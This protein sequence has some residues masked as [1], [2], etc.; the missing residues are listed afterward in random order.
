MTN[1]LC[2]LCALQFG[3]DPMRTISAKA[4]TML[5]GHV[6]ASPLDCSL[7]FASR[8]SGVGGRDSVLITHEP[9]AEP[10]FPAAA[11][12]RLTATLAKKHEVARKS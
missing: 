3:S 7:M 6:N 8:P 1:L 5:R 4:L 2:C 9:N 11:E 10:I 12:A